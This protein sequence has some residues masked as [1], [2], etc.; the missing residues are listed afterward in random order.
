MVARR[1]DGMRVNASMNEA[2]DWMR[3]IAKYLIGGDDVIE[4]GLNEK[5]D[6]LP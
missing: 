6:E 4:W 3:V 5:E 1:F 2:F